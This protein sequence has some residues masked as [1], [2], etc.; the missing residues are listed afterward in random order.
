MSHPSVLLACTVT[1][2]TSLGENSQ[3]C[4]EYVI[5]DPTR[6]SFALVVQVRLFVAVIS[7]RKVAALLEACS[8]SVQI[9]TVMGSTLEYSTRAYSG[10]A[11]SL[12]TQCA[13]E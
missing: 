2:A 4:T 5:C 1:L 8:S 10:Y 7:M 12:S 13:K 11:G 9:S 3:N 6:G